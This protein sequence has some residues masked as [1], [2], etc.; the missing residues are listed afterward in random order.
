MRNCYAGKEE[1]EWSTIITVLHRMN[2]LNHTLWSVPSE[3][4]GLEDLADAAK[5]DLVGR[6]LPAAL[7]PDRCEEECPGVAVA[8][9]AVGAE[10]D[11]QPLLLQLPLLSP[12]LLLV[13]LPA[14]LVPGSEKKIQPQVGTRICVYIDQTIYVQSQKIICPKKV[15]ITKNETNTRVK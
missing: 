7:A 13:N 11:S 1:A 2:P 10:A 9:V 12:R 14:S 4:S 6:L 8:G 3:A 15:K 5:V